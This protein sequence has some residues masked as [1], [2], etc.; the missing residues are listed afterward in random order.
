MEWNGGR[1]SSL[2]NVGLN[3]GLE[4]AAEFLLGES[5]AQVPIEDLA[6]QQSGEVSTDPE[7]HKAAVSYDTAYAVRQHEL[8][9]RHDPGRRRKFLEI[10]WLSKRQEMCD[11]IGAAIRRHWHL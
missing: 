8:Q 6:L 2:L 5:N 9:Y 3:A 1:Y 4:D 7:R 11:I 10:P